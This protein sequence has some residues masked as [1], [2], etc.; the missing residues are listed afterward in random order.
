M[1][2][3]I[4]TQAVDTQDPVLGFFHEW[5][6]EL[7][8]R[9]ESVEVI[10][11]KEGEYALP[12]NVRV[13]SLGKEKGKKSSFM[14]ALRFL[15]LAWKL[16]GSYDAVFVHMNQEYVLL[17][18]S[19]WKLLGK[20]AYL[21]RNHY[22]GSFL[23]DLAAMYCAKVFYTSKSSYSARYPHALQ[24]P[25]GVDTK[26]FAP[27]ESRRAPR[28]I[29][30]LA[31]MAPSKR[32][33]MLV[34]ALEALHAQGISFKASFVGSPLEEY[35]DFY[36]LLVERAQALGEVSFLPAVTH[37]RAAELYKEHAIFVNT[38]PPGMLDKTIFEAAASGCRVYAASTDVREAFGEQSFF[39]DVRSLAERLK[40][41]LA[42]GGAGAS[43]H[44]AVE[45][46]SLQALGAILSKTIH[47]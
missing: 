4:V 25:V 6:R 41:G 38:S 9:F 8:G 47:D 45:A 29:L 19:L 14:Y 30:F 17:A 15:S 16:R 12:D 36:R 13:H 20:K 18:G 22:A 2:L 21:W 28:S 3:L 46:N 23:T 5:I 32:P 10:C 34:E 7:A 35:K 26:R 44:E 31:R 1:K 33:Q 24:M 27:D 39:I 42:E 11:L 43:L 37:E 40:E